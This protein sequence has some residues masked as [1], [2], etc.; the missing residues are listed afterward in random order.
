MLR[1]P[2]FHFLKKE[3]MD[4]YTNFLQKQGIIGKKNAPNK[5]QNHRI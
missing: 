2:T 4:K 3:Y 5:K 1:L